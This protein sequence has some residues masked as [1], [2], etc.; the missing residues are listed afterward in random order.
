V[1][2][3]LCNNAVTPINNLTV[4]ESGG[5]CF[6]AVSLRTHF[7][8]K[9]I[10]VIL[11]ALTASTSPSPLHLRHAA[12][13]TQ[14]QVLQVA[15]VPSQHDPAVY[16]VTVTTT[17]SLDPLDSLSN[18]NSL[19]A[20]CLVV[21]ATSV[22]IT[23]LVCAVVKRQRVSTSSP[24]MTSLRWPSSPRLTSG[25]RDKRFLLPIYE[26]PPLS[27][28]WVDEKRVRPLFQP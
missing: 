11:T 17:V 14:R 13:D 27:V 28:V 22:F 25:D 6:V 10:G 18:Y 5:R 20:I 24:V 21:V 7:T 2:T 12:G 1:S 23:C 4:T 26:R 3:S 19:I 8:M 16:S 9:L 15:V